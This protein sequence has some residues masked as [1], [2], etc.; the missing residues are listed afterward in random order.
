MKKI[1]V[2]INGFGRIGRQI[3]R[4]II[5]NYDNYIEVV[6]INDLGDITTNAHLFKYDSTY[7]SIKNKVFVDNNNLIIDNKKIE[8]TNENNPKNIVWSRLGAEIIIESTGVFTDASQA[9]GHLKNGANKVIISAPATNE[10]ITIVMGVN[11]EDYDSKKHSIISNA[12]CTTNCV[13]L[14]VKILHENFGVE[15]A[16]MSTI[17][18]YTNDQNTLDQNHSDLRRARSANTNII[19][20]TTGAAKAV[21]KVIPELSG[22]IDGMAYRVPVITGSVT[23][24]TVQLSKKTTPEKINEAYHIASNKRY[25]GLL[26]I[27]ME[28]LVS[29]D[30]IGSNYSCIIDGLSTKDLGNDFVKVV[31]WYDNEWGYAN[32]L[33]DLILHISHN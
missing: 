4:N 28:P 19:P 11:Q 7:G 22:R 5:E 33:I 32:R 3:L 12:S 14:M 13:A 1:K 24:L 21:T 23:D 30:Y 17:H 31:G 15:K 18:A 2:G 20:T 6:A 16:L 25:K 8:F 10:D 29:S 9:S 27:S 26:D